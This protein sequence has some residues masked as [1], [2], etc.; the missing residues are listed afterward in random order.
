M[1]EQIIVIGGG[2]HAKVV[3]DCIRSAGDTVFGIL[4]DSLAVGGTVFDIPVLGKTEDYVRFADEKFIVAIG[5]NTVRRRLAENMDV[6]WHTAVHPR[7]VVSQYAKLGKGSVVMPGAII[8]AGTN[9]GDH[10]IINTGAVVEHDNRIGDYVHISP[11]AS[12]GGTVEVGDSTHVGIGASVKNN[13]TICGG[14]TI[15]AG[16]VVVKD[17]AECGVYVGVPAHKK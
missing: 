2:G 4:D 7:A 12:L 8:N 9:I 17:I 10:C 14:C 13:I 11:A 6:E 5:N 15:G 3:I 1:S 16:A